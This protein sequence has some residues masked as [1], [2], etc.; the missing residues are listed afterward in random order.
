MISPKTFKE[1]GMPY[2][3]EVHEKL[4]ELGSKHIFKHICGEQNKN[5]E[6][7]AE[8]PMGDPGFVSFG[9]EVEVEKAAEYFPKDVIVGNLEPAIIATATADEVYEASKKL[10]EKGQEVPRRIHVRSGLR[11][12]AMAPPEN[13]KAISRALNDFGYY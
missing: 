13:V 1:F 6:A 4:I 11:A 2:V 7:W 10:I 3:K 8:V 12:A 9:H 5:L